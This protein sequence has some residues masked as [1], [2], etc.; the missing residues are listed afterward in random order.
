[1]AAN[2]RPRSLTDF[3]ITIKTYSQLLSTKLFF[4]FRNGVRCMTQVQAERPPS[5]E[6]CGCATVKVGRLS[7]IGSHPL[8]NVYKCQPCRQIISITSAPFVSDLC[9]RPEDV[10]SRE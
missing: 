3:I 8:I 6:N 10:R 2:R 1:M 5:C 4:L 7:R 9:I